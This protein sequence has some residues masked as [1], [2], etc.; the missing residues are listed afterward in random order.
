MNAVMAT[1]ILGPLVQRIIYRTYDPWAWTLC[2]GKFEGRQAY[3][4]SDWMDEMSRER[5][6]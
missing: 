6:E 2:F 3:C 4:L 5:A 1:L